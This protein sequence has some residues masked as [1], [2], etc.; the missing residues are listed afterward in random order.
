MCCSAAHITVTE[1][2][3]YSPAAAFK[4]KENH[5]NDVARGVIIVPIQYSSMTLGSVTLYICVV[6]MMAAVCNN[7]PRR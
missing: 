4:K 5:P 6:L 7:F 2:E 3:I 1:G